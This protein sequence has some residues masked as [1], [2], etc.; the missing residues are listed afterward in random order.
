MDAVRG[1]SEICDQN[2][3]E[4]TLREQTSAATMKCAI[5]ASS[6]QNHGLSR[7]LF[8]K[9]ELL[10][11]CGVASLVLSLE[12]FKVSAAVG[13]HF[14]ESAAGMV[15]FLMRFKVFCEFVDASRENSDLNL[16]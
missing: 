15:V 8:S 10:D 12:V 7:D 5:C 9:F 4:C 13:N 16:G 3:L 14:Q 1:A 11:D 2:V 6:K